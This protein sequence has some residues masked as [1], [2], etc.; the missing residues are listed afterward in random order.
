MI[1]L[2]DYDW[3][4]QQQLWEK[5]LWEDRGYP[6]GAAE[7][8]GSNVETERSKPLTSASG[9]NMKAYTTSKESRGWKN[10]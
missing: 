3:T 8:G 9:G 1:R 4:R 5:Q 6:Q 2:L 7:R 10:Q